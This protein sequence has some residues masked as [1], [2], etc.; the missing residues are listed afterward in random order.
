MKLYFV[1]TNEYKEREVRS[2]LS[3]SGIEVVV[4]KHR[5]QEILDVDLEKVVRDKCL[6]AFEKI[7]SPVAVEHG[8]LCMNGLDG[9]PGGLSKAVWDSIGGKI[10]Q[11]I[12]TGASREAVHRVMVAYCDGHRVHVFEGSTKGTIPD[13]PRGDYAFQY[14]PVFVPEGSERT[15]AE[16]GLPEKL[17]YSPATKAWAKLVAHLLPMGAK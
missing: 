12:P 5:V 14:D 3:S 2:I 11:T 15:L 9:L 4:L 7:R 8:A 13:A 16:L 6:K 17:K 10:C 1:T